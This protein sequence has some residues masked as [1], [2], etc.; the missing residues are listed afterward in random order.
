MPSPRR[1]AGVDACVPAGRLAPRGRSGERFVGQ[2]SRSPIG[3]PSPRGRCCARPPAHRC[4]LHTGLPRSVSA[5]ARGGSSRSGAR[6]SWE[7]GPCAHGGRDL[8]R[9]PGCTGTLVRACRRCAPVLV[10]DAAV[11]GSILRVPQCRN[12]ESIGGS[13]LAMNVG[14]CGMTKG[15]THDTT[16]PCCCRSGFLTLP[17]SRTCPVQCTV[18][19]SSRQ[20]GSGMSPV[21][22]R[23]TNGFVLAS[24]KL[25]WNIYFCKEIHTI[26]QIWLQKVTPQ[27]TD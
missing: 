2:R 19:A 7:A 4:A 20:C 25:N 21:T 9:M 18:L 17:A 15:D 13:F 26:E 1:V 5:S 27:G 16:V 23:I 24:I 11:P 3:A 10:S 12:G 8:G 22:V 6:Q 14:A